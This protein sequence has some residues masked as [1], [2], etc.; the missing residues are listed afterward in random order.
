[1]RLHPREEKTRKARKALDKAINKIAEK[2]GLTYIEKTLM[3]QRAADERVDGYLTYELR[4]ERHGDYTRPSGVD[5]ETD[6]K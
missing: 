3:L 1:M 2:Y 4:F 5:F 6:K